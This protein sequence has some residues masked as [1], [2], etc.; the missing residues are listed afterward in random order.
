V[1]IWVSL[2]LIVV[3]LGATAVLSLRAEPR[4]PEPEEGSAAERDEERQLA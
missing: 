3:I 2:A 1:P 4:P